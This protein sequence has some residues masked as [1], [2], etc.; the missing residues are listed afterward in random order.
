M[1]QG[2][3]QELR[4]AGITIGLSSHDMLLVDGLLDRAYFLEQGN[5]IETFDATKNSLT[6]DS[7]MYEFIK[8]G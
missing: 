6:H 1:L 5:I 2:I 4:D 3:I 8:H 7:K